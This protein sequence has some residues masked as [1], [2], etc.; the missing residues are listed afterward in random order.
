MKVLDA[1]NR[2]ER[3]QVNERSKPVLRLLARGRVG[4]TACGDTGGDRTGVSGG[5]RCA[6]SNE[7]GVG[8]HLQW[9]APKAPE[10]LT[11]ARRTK[12]GGT[13]E[14]AAAGQLDFA[15]SGVGVDEVRARAAE[16][17]HGQA[18]EFWERIL[19]PANLNEACRRVRENGRAA[20]ID[21]MSVAAFP[22]FFRVHGAA[23]RAK[24]QAGTRRPLP[25]A[26]G[27]DSEEVRR[28]APAGHPDGAGPRDPAS[29]SAKSWVGCSRKRSVKTVTPT[30]P[31]AARTTHCERSGWRRTKE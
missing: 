12:P 1:R 27:G 28:G 11:A 5:C 31:V 13:A 22:A 26:A 14:T 7:P 8:N 25:V 9:G 6:R 19:A 18:G 29:P 20:G 4:G 2:R 17:D 15:L 21:G 24:L 16:K 23:M 3:P 10:G 30:G